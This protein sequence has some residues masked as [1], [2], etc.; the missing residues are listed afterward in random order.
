MVFGLAWKFP[1]GTI[2]SSFVYLV[3]GKFVENSFLKNY[4][5]VVATIKSGL[6]FHL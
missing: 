4:F 1:A 2:M 5:T 6:L 3:G